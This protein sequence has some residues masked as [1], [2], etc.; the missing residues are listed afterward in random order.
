MAL[1]PAPGVFEGKILTHEDFMLIQQYGA[2]HVQAIVRAF[3]TAGA[4]NA[5]VYGFEHSLTG[6]MSVRIAAPGQVYTPADGLTY[7]WFDVAN[8]NDVALAPAHETQARWDIIIA[9]LETDARTDEQLTGYGQ[10]CS[11]DEYEAVPQVPQYPPRNRAV[12]RQ[13]QNRATVTVLT[14]LPADVPEAP[15]LAVNELPL[16]LVRVAPGV[17]DIY[18]AD[19]TDMR[20]R[21]KSLRMAWAAIED[22]RRQLNQVLQ[23]V[24]RLPAANIDIGAGGG[25]WEGADVQK[26]INDYANRLAGETPL[27]HPETLT[28]NGK[29][30]TVGAMDG[31]TPVADLPAGLLVAFGSDRVFPLEP[32]RFPANVLA[33]MVNKNVNAGANSVTHEILTTLATITEE[34]SDGTG[35]FAKKNAVLPTGRYQANAAARGDRFV[36]IFGGVGTGALSQWLTYDTVADT[37]TPRVLTGVAPPASPRPHLYPC[38]VNHSD[39]L[40]AAPI[41]NTGVIRWFRVNGAT[42]VSMEIMGGP[43]GKWA[44]GDLIDV[45]TIFVQASND[46]VER[47]TYIFHVADN[48]FEQVNPSGIGPTG[49]FNNG[50]GC[51]YKV[52]QLLFYQA[53]ETFLFDLPTLSWTPLNIAPPTVL[54][55]GVVEPVQ[56]AP[57]R[58]AY[59]RPLLVDYQSGVAVAWE[60]EPS[61]TPRWREVTGSG[62]PERTLFSMASLRNES[63]LGGAAFVFGG[64]NPSGDSQTDIYRYNRGGIVPTTMPDGSPAITLGT[65]TRQARFTVAVYNLPWAVGAVYATL[66]GTLPPGSFALDYSFDNGVTFKRVPRDKRTAIAVTSNPAIRVLRV[67]LIGTAT[68]KPVLQKITETMEQTGQ[69]TLQELVLRFNVLGGVQALYMD[70]KGKVTLENTIAPSTPGKAILVKITPQGAAPPLVKDYINQRVVAIERRATRAGGV[71]PPIMNDLAML[72]KLVSPIRVKANGDLA[73]LAVPAVVFDQDIAVAGLLADGDSYRVKLI[74]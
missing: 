29:L 41:S 44:R 43:Q 68:S 1:L 23:G 62:A 6:G 57:L 15:A 4:L 69:A 56:S 61:D 10:L 74:V 72:P 65:D 40:V 16:Y 26:F 24:T 59:G 67:T 20:D 19:V 48:T 27:A 51:I 2:E 11:E 47:R 34:W 52:G 54:V 66:V 14:G 22:I 58:N 33:R 32:A 8:F 13:L 73:D 28:S 71:T 70:D 31:G 5:Q 9:R 21:V 49:Q 17:E 30:G 25:A 18:D 12:A 60:V 64:R 35:L 42:G 3:L 63:L 46:N 50:T 39:V 7:D 55:G 53:G 45:N 37:I 38:G 36:E